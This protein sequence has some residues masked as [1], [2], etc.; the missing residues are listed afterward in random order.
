LGPN[1]ATEEVEGK[2]KKGREIDLLLKV[3][4]LLI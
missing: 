4:Y 3:T 2:E 1:L